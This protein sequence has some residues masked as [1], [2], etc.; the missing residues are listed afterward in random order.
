MAGSS[1]SKYIY[2][3]GW[4]ANPCCRHLLRHICVFNIHRANLWLI[5]HNT[6]QTLLGFWERTHN[7]AWSNV[8]QD[9][10]A[11]NL[12]YM[13]TTIDGFSAVLSTQFHSQ[14]LGQIMRW[15]PSTFQKC[16]MLGSSSQVDIIKKSTFWQ[17]QWD[18]N[19]GYLVGTLKF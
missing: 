11:Q 1:F 2:L 6:E 3:L 19:P 18:S 14:C 17:L 8:E 15:F 9:Q 16:R 12:V 4:R 7:L 5:L 10:Y 13:S